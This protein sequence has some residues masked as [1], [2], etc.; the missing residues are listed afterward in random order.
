[1]ST[2]YLA[3]VKAW[4]GTSETTLYFSSSFYVTGTTNLPTGGAAHTWYDPRIQ[5]PALMRRDCWS[6]GTTGGESTIGYGTLDLS[7]ALS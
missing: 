4:N 3:H 5:Q 1:M 6:K 7:N 2:I